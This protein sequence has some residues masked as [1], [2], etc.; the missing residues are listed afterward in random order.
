MELTLAQ[1]QALYQHGYVEVPGAVPRAAVER[2]LRAINAS[3]GSQG[4]DPAR[5]DQFR[6]QT[7]CPELTGNEAITDLINR[8]PLFSLCESAVGAGQLRPV[9]GG[10][11]ALRFPGT[12]QPRAPGPHI[13]GMYSP[14]NGVKQG[15]IANFTALVGVFLSDVPGPFC[16]NFS[17]WPGTH[18]QFEAYFREAGPQALL[19]GMPKV[20]MPPYR[21]MTAAAGDAVI[22]HYQLGHGVAGNGAP[23]TRYGIFFRLTHV[24]HDAVHWEC[25]TDIWREWAGM[26]EV[27]EAAE[28]ARSA[29][30]A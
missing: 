4:I 23:H 11:I 5:L 22:C 13:D 19:E 17:V 6:A 2:A 9:R 24:D 30:P 16:G 20:E 10:Q 25:M 28:P 29:A 8:S 21:Q 15:T 12:G 7:Y 14:T 3:L 18:R 1:K 27:V 26:R